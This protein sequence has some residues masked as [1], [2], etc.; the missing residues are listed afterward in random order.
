MLSDV[1]LVML[2]RVALAAVLGLAIGWERKATGS[3][4]KAR[5]AALAALTAASLTALSLEIFDTGT[6]RIV[7]GL[8]TGIG[9]LGAGAI[10]HGAGG[11]VRG[12]TTAASMWAMTGVGVAVGAGHALFGV[13]LT[14]LI[15]L[16]IAWGEWPAL[17]QMRQWR[18][19]RGPEDQDQRP[20]GQPEP[21]E[22]A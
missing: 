20:L 19:R 10:I 6:D 14:V 7:Q 22:P 17:V 8:V 4:I 11:E 5:I 13:L 3:T 1:E 12:L 9:F 18:S 21:P 2:G 16:I 15:Y